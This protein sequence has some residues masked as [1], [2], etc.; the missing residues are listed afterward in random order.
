ML[1]QTIQEDLKN[2]HTFCQMLQ[3]DY[4]K[5]KE[6]NVFGKTC[7]QESKNLTMCLEQY[8]LL[9]YT[10]GVSQNSKPKNK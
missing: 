5:C 3:K 9:S 6:N 4:T 10:C 2:L 8:L 7:L 1:I